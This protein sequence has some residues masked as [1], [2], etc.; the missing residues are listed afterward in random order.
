MDQNQSL[1]VE[2]ISHC[3]ARFHRRRLHHNIHRASAYLSALAV[4][5]IL[6]AGSLILPSSSDASTTVVEIPTGISCSTN[7]PSS[8]QVK[9]ATIDIYC[10]GGAYWEDITWSTWGPSM[11]AGTGFYVENDCVP[12]CGDGNNVSQGEFQMTASALVHRS[13]HTYFSKLSA[14]MTTYGGKLLL[15]NEPSGGYPFRGIAKPVGFVTP[16]PAAQAI[17]NAEG[18]IMQGVQTYLRVP[19]YTYTVRA[20]LIPRDPTWAVFTVPVTPDGL[21]FGSGGTGIAHE[22]GSRWSI[23][24]YAIVDCIGSGASAIPSTVSK[25]YQSQANV[26]LNNCP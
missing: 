12:N 14:V 6:V 13:G 3:P 4:G 1:C 15:M 16:S 18:Q 5:T 9:P 22:S 10:N 20:T 7:Q 2:S 25:Y 19:F 23:E 21:G 17:A 26:D 11:A 8:W 24:R